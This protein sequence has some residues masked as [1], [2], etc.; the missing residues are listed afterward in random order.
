[1]NFLK[2]IL[3]TCLTKIKPTLKKRHGIPAV[4]YS[5]Q[6]NSKGMSKTGLLRV[7]WIARTSNQPIL[8]EINPEN[9]LEGLML[10]LKLRYFSH[11]MQRA[12]SL[13]KTL[14]LGKTEGKRKREQQ[15][16]RWLDSTTDS[17]DMNLSKLWEIVKDRKAWHA[18][19]NGVTKSWTR[20]SN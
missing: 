11:P 16:I 12:N 10:K 19:V 3:E 18:A 2:G 5:R 9:S 6:E 15:R 4:G 8:K 1:M 20:L 7:P 17:M 14:M 13:E